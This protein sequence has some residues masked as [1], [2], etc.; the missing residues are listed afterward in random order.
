MADKTYYATYTAYSGRAI[1]SELMETTDF[2][3]FPDVAAEW[4]RGDGTREWRCFRERS[5][6]GTR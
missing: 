3:V 4:N 6:A 5:T 2:R 1:R